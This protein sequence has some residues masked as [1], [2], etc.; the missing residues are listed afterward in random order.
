VRKPLE[1]IGRLKSR[2]LEEAEVKEN[3][4]ASLAQTGLW[5][6]FLKVIRGNYN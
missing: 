3:L 1:D 5:N 2:N 6:G 4:S